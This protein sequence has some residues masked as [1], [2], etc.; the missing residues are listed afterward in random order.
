MVDPSLQ[1]INDREAQNGEQP[2]PTN[3]DGGAVGGSG[4]AIPVPSISKTHLVLVAVVIVA[5]LVWR[6]RS[7]DAPDSSGA[8]QMELA[9]NGDFSS[10]VEATPEGDDY[11][12]EEAGRA[13]IP[14]NPVNQLEKDEAALRFLMDNGKFGGG[15]S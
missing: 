11:D 3:S 15:A 12:P 8:E 6:S 1:E 9:R 10:E 5:I 13:R 2:Q 4:P 7:A 14:V